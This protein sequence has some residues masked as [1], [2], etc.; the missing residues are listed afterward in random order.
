MLLVEVCKA[1]FTKS[2]C[3]ADSVVE[4]C[5]ADSAMEAYKAASAERVEACC[6]HP[7]CPGYG[8]CELSKWDLPLLSAP[9]GSGWSGVSLP[10]AVS[11]SDHN[12]GDELCAVLAPVFWGCVEADDALF[13]LN[14]SLRHE[15]LG[16]RA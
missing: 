9:T 6:Y 11:I 2:A 16:M 10:I 15:V 1:A 7:A 8:G 12:D 13:K 14:L 4:A 3:K 5:Q